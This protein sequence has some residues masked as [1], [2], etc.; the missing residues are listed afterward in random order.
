MRFEQE[1][2]F[3]KDDT[4]LLGVL[5]ALLALLAL[6]AWH[7]WPA[8]AEEIVLILAFIGLAGLLLNLHRMRQAEARHYLEHI[9]G[10]HFLHQVLPL[11]APLPPL[12]GWAA[13]PQ[14]ASTLISLIQK[15]T[16]ANVLELGSGASTV[17]MAYALETVGAGHLLAVD[18]DDTYARR[19][20]RLLEE[21]GLQEWATVEHAPLS[22]HSLNDQSQRWYDLETVS[23]AVAQHTPIDL[24]VV[25]G[26]PY[27][28]CPQARCPVVKYL[29]KHLSEHAIIV[30][31]DALRD[32]EQAA[33]ERWMQTLNTLDVRI[34]DTA[35]GIAIL[36]RAARRD[37]VEPRMSQ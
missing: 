26:P 36:K 6:A 16:P 9:Q 28:T 22:K 23:G 33:I 18:H 1:W 34:Q 30:H 7:L 11:R 37:P 25:D 20:R 3:Q 24:L 2:A 12:T 15:E 29:H 31:D 4:R 5:A 27:E 10:V 13:S 14:L 8:G 35:K 21:H 32:D 19:T 17:A